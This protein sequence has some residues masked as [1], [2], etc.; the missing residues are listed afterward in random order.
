MKASDLFVKALEQEGVNF[1]FGIPGEE[2]LDMLESIRN[3]S[4]KL[5]LT[6]HEQA[7]GFMA[8]TYGRLTGKVGVCLSTLGPGATN[9][10]TAAAYSQLG[11]MP[12]LMITGQK[13]IKASKQGR[14]QVLNVVDMM[15]PL[16]K[17]T[18]QIVSGER[19]ASQVRE[20]FRM[21]SAERPGAAHLELPEDIATEEVKPNLITESMFRR[22]V[23]EDKA[24][25][26]AVSMIE[27]AKTPIL[28]IGAAA[29]RKMT[30]KMLSRFVKQTK[31]PFVTTQ[32]GKG[33]I[34]ETNPLF[35]GNTTLSDGDFVH[36]VIEHAD[37][38]INVGHDVVEKPPFFMRTNDKKVI[39][40]NYNAAEVDQV[41]FPQVEVVGDIANGIWSILEKIQNQN[42]W[43]FSYF[44][45]VKAAEE[46]E[47]PHG[48]DD[49][50]FPIY[51]Q[52]LVA[53]VRR[54]MPDDGIIALD[55]GVYKIWF[56]RN[57][58]AKLPN[59]VLLDNALATMGAG[60]PSAMAAKLVYPHRPV[61]AVCGDGG[62]MMNSQEL[63][64]AVRLKQ[65]LI[66]LILRDDA[67]GMIK[68]KQANM[69]FNDFGLD[70]GN[71]DFVKYIESYG[72]KGH[73]LSSAAELLPLLQACIDK[74]AVHLIDA[75]IDYSDND[76][77]LNIELPKLSARV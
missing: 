53:D 37:L 50:R 3:S 72:G 2:N 14:F 59:T 77:I 27:L 74:P 29:N 68:W 54:A 25:N 64:T 58:K 33:V 8:A 10:V 17:Y 38:I 49:D 44:D 9:L 69:Q 61:I 21:A 71:P 20:A 60:L 18:A 7:A 43:N 73:R 6:R 48:C 42:H 30:S 11:A 56:A 47:L 67:Y 4:I 28:L 22:P 32:M 15:R 35:L 46:K 40:I 1:I 19:I 63:E 65:H 13:P 41:Y 12:M 51:P 36:R 57:Y 70:Y 62:F 55:N 24:I 75:P 66:V 34:D 45:K 26:K 52:R 16:T 39:H 31:I 5:I 76:R 23:A